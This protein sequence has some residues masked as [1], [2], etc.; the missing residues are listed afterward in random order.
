M[1]SEG[2]TMN[3]F[4]GSWNRKS[5]ITSLL[6]IGSASVLFLILNQIEAYNYLLFH[7]IAESISF[8]SSFIIFIIVVSVWSQLHNNYLCFLGIAFFF[9]GTIDLI[10]MLTYKGMQIF[11]GFNEN[12]PTQLWIL[13]RY[14]QALSLLVGALLIKKRHQIN[15]YLIFFIYSIIVG[16]S[17]GMI[18]YWKIFPECFI[19]GYGLTPF[20]IDSEYVI[21]AIL[22]VSMTIMMKRRDFFNQ[23]TLRL[24][25]VSIVFQ[26]IAEIAFTVYS[27]VYAR[28]IFIGHYFKIL[29][30]VLFCRATVATVVG[31]LSE[32][33]FEKLKKR[34]H[35]LK[36]AQRIG[37]MGSWE[38]NLVNSHFTWSNQ[39]L[40]ILEFDKSSTRLSYQ[41][42]LERIH[43]EDREQRKKNF[44][45]A[46]ENRGTYNSIHRLLMA[47]GTMKFVHERGEISYDEENN[48]Q[49]MSCI[50]KDITEQKKIEEEILRLNLDLEKIVMERTIQ[51][52]E[53]NCEL[54]AG[55]ATLEE[56]ISEREKV[57]EKINQLNDQLEDKVKERTSQ[58]DQLNNVLDASNTLLSAILDSSPEIIV[59]SLDVYYCYLTFNT[60]H[61]ETMLGIWGKNIEVGE[62]Y[63]DAL[64]NGEAIHKAEQNFQRVLAGESFTL[65]EEYDG[66]NGVR[67]FCQNYWSPIFS[68]DGVV[69]GITCFAMDITEQKRAEE[70]LRQSEQRLKTM[71]EQAPLGIAVIDSVT[72]KIVE[73]NL[74]FAEIIGRTVQE[75]LT[76]DWMDF[77]YPDDMQDS[78]DHMALMNA[79]KITGFHLNKRYIHLDGSVVW[80]NLTVAPMKGEVEG[81]PR[82]LCMIEDITES[83]LLHER[84]EK[85]QILAEKANDVMMFLDYEG[86]IIE[87]NDAAIRMY[88]YTFEELLSMTIFD[89]RRIEKTTEIMAQ[90]TRAHQAGILFETSHYRKDGTS[91]QVEVS[92]QGNLLGKTKGLLSIVRDVTERKKAQAEIMSALK[93]AEEANLAKSQF[94]ANMSHE[95]RTPMNGIIGMTELTLMTELEE[96]QR[97]YLNIVK[98]STKSL[99]RVLNDI[100]DY[101]KF[102]AGKIQ[103]E[104]I[105]FDLRKTVN[106]VMELFDI[107]AK[108]KGLSIRGSIDMMI[109][110]KVIGDCVRLRQILSNL[111]GN[112]I[113]FTEQGEVVIQVHL[114]EKYDNRAKLKFIVTDTGIGIP[115]DKLGKLFKRFSQVDESHTRRFGGTGLGL[116]IS[117]KLIE[118]MGGEIG[119]ESTEYVG[120]NFFFTAV[121]GFDNN[122]EIIT[123]D[124][125]QRQSVKRTPQMMGKLLLAEDDVVSRNMLMIVLKGEGFDIVAVENGAEAVVAFEKEQFDVILMDVNMPY[126]DG[127]SATAT[128]RL[129]EKAMNIHTPII[130]MT[131]YAL[132]GDREKCLSAGM[133]NYISKPID[134]GEITDMIKKQIQIVDGNDSELESNNAFKKIVADLMEASGF[135][136]ETSSSIVSE[137]CGQT[138][139]ILENIR[140]NLIAQKNEEA[141]VLV[142]QLKGSA[143]NVRAKEI[144]KQALRVEEAMHA[145]DDGM[146]GSVLE[147]I[148]ARVQH[149]IKSSKEG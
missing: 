136:Q 80:V 118:I 33:F 63:L 51:L 139:R 109:P 137:F 108:Q 132:K 76:S 95:I 35:Q 22:I 34:Q 81:N 17:F 20:K 47:N 54:E 78:L 43:P 96:E 10:H 116:A 111:I 120:S 25:V 140:R 68:N 24:L 112:A 7:S 113:K 9:V 125:V 72:G 104:K 148:E 64:G 26:I 31:G 142:H 107:G 49:K 110:G 36:Q 62:N 18:F 133:D 115:A 32:F 146:V 77:T 123:S 84:L 37:N 129:K 87:V 128:I 127:Y 74:R 103:L 52:E 85:Y 69:I 13:V 19:E 122:L 86:N 46:I 5:M 14:I 92:S 73:V 100:L 71:F 98:S 56:E 44:I 50:I 30:V 114:V 143:G 79:N 101:S 11:S 67:L 42:F 28:S 12:L 21:C 8:L 38:L 124:S 70:A 138:V 147:D 27:N 23:E 39:T 117:K 65:I 105:S 89:L 149:L 88:G 61:Q 135:D 6:Y 4:L 40:I 90:I 131:A 94:L 58:L 93:K 119:V 2:T 1:K 145:L 55:N 53:M 57:E 97:E 121:F 60:R 144:A 16:L 99:L 134:F 83:R 75:T 82:H 59:F 29:S 141:K 41:I 91:V 126:L 102:E 66:Q 45:T 48:P 130:A 3:A 106:E 15:S